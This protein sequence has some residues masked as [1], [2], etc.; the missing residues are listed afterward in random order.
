MFFTFV[1]ILNYVKQYNPNVLFLQENVGSAPREDV[2]IMS[3]RLGVYPVKINSSLVTAQSRD[4]YYWTNIRT[5]KDGLF[6]DL[7]T[8]IPLPKDRN[9]MLKDV[10]ESGYVEKNKSATLLERTAEASTFKDMKG[11]KAQRYLKIRAFKYSFITIVKEDNYYRL[12][13]Q[14]ELEVL[15]GFPKGY[16]KILRYNHASSLLGDGWTLPVIEHIFSFIKDKKGENN[17]KQK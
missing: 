15:Q 6:G 12:F 5:R 8:D 2:G 11:Q 1:D 17:A 9:I 13:N 3:R 10:I 7:V 14:N 16:T 4:R